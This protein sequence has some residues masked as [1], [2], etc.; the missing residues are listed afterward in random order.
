MPEP[1]DPNIRLEL[2]RSRAET[3]SLKRQLAEQ[4]KQ[5][6]DL[7]ASSSWQ[8]TAPFR[9]VASWVK[10]HASRARGAPRVRE[11]ATSIALAQ[12]RQWL[13]SY[14]TIDPGTRAAMEKSVESLAVCPIISIIMPV[15]NI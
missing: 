14:G 2:D 3:L 7:L 12:Y 8:L 9:A 1:A 10:R 5:T 6:D 11:A 13:K 4:K 15:Y